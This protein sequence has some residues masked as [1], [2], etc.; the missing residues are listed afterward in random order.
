MAEIEFNLENL[1]GSNGFGFTGVTRQE[2]VG[3]SVSIL[4]D[5][6]GDGIDD[7]AFGAPASVASNADPAVH[8]VFGQAGGFPV[9]LFPSNDDAGTNRLT[10]VGGSGNINLGFAVSGAGDVNG[11]GIHDLIVGDTAANPAGEFA[12]SGQSFVVF[13]RS[14]N[15]PLPRIL[16]VDELDGS[17][18]FAIDGAVGDRA[19]TSVSGAGDV[20]GDGVD[21]YLVGAPD[22]N[23][24]YLIYG[25]TGPQPSRID[26]AQL[27]SSQGVVLTGVTD[28]FAGATVRDIGDFNGDG[29]DD[30]AIAAP[31]ARVTASVGDGSD[32]AN[33][34]LGGRVY[35]VYGDSNLAPAIDL[36][37]LD[38]SNGFVFEA[39][40]N[41]LDSPR[42]GSSLDGAGDFNADGLPDLIIGSRAADAEGRED[43]GQ[44]HI[45]F[46]QSTGIPAQLTRAELDGTNGLTIVGEL[47]EQGL[48]L[49]GDTAGA[50]VS[51]I[52]DF[53]QDGADDVAI[54]APRG[55]NGDIADVGRTYVVYGR[56]NNT[57][58]V[59]DLRNLPASDG[60][61]LNGIEAFDGDGLDISPVLDG[62]SGRVDGGGDVNGDGVPDLVIGN[63]AAEL[64]GFV[65]ASAGAG[66]VLFSEAD[67]T[68]P[69]EP[70]VGP[71]EP[72]EPGDTLVGGDTDDV[73]IGGTGNDT[74]IG[75]AGNDTL[76]GNDGDDQLQGGEDN[77]FL[78]G[79]VGE[80]ILAGGAGSDRLVGGLGGDRLRGGDGDDRLF[81]KP[82]VDIIQA[83][84]GDDTLGGGKGNDVLEG[85]DG[86]DTLRGKR[87]D[88][89]L[90]G[91]SGD[92]TLWGGNGNDTLDGEADDDDLFGARGR[93]QLNGGFGDDTLNGGRGTDTLDGGAGND[94]LTGGRK[95]DT[96]TGGAGSDTFRYADLGESLLS[97]GI[98][99]TFDRI[100]DFAIGT[101]RIESINAV[102]A[103]NILQLGN[104]ASLDEAGLQAVLEASSFAANGAATFS[105]DARDFLALNDGIAG[106]QV[107]SDALIEITGFTGNLAALAIA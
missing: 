34:V 73:L 106:Y 77:D 44:A 56:P 78:I 103:S 42:V 105:F 62:A 13:G 25:R 39:N 104:A 54:V 60:F 2:L 58:A 46:G 74:L 27:T 97:N 90:L 82:G 18:G 41:L 79:G 17:N 80:D 101:D 67:A 48:N 37:A 70:P 12:I 5:I 66:Y 35:V 99:I 3:T 45:I 16:N 1:N 91:G 63:P 69:V 31:S 19:G 6:N 52:G 32:P 7:V 100:T 57:T 4:S 75:N 51:G 55:D 87:D 107:S 61:V 11:D 20:N 47:G 23:R 81:G 71:P 95:A 15:Q 21:D 14:G 93:D 40:D 94:T 98:A 68:A 96:L 92:D 22:N 36:S 64:L 85:E 10:I 8:I 30:I 88:D 59:L 65:N 86:D 26:L 29:F 53:N 89:L 38:G 24:A 50:A 102:S 83:G 28:D 84:A 72:P 43:A 9:G 76:E 33:I 49:F